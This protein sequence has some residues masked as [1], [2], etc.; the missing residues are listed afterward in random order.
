MSDIRIK[1][2]DLVAEVRRLAD[3]QPDFIY[4]QPSGSHCSYRPQG[5][6]DGC[7]VGQALRR[8]GW[9][10]P[11]LLDDGPIDDNIQEGRFPVDA[12]RA[13]ARWLLS[14]QSWQDCGA[15]WGKAIH[16]TDN[17]EIAA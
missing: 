11:F 15:S 16:Y 2:S 13:E 17:K 4:K 3:E 9:E 8:L 14:I 5:G 6:N 7:I 12:T 1:G 10:V